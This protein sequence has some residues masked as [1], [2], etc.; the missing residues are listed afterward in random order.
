MGVGIVVEKVY[1]LFEQARVFLLDSFLSDI[2]VFCSS[3]L[4]HYFPLFQEF[5]FPLHPKMPSVAHS[6][7]PIVHL[8]WQ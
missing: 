6:F 1:F 3:G 4:L 7:V 2:A 8:H 5:K